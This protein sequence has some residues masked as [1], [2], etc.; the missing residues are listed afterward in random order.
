MKKTFKA[1]AH[2]KVMYGCICFK[3]AKDVNAFALS[4]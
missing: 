2:T 3:L 1:A 4:F